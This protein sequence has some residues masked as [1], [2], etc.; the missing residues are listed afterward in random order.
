MDPLAQPHIT[1]HLNLKFRQCNSRSKVTS[2]IAANV[3]GCASS[4]TNSE[5]MGQQI[6]LNDLQF[7]N[8]TGSITFCTSWNKHSSLTLV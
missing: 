6:H 2:R 3:T 7:L 8:K 4:K 5:I 1:S